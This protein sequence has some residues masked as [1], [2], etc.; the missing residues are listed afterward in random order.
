MLG[1]PSIVSES[2]PF[3]EIQQR[4]GGVFDDPQHP[5]AAVRFGDPR[6]EYRAARQEAALF[7][8]SGRVQ[9]EL[10]GRDRAKFLHNFCT[11][12]IKS[13]SAGQ[14]REAFVTNVQGKVLAH[15]FVYADRD[16]LW[17]DSGPETA[18][19]LLAHLS[20]Y[21][22]SEDV[23]FHDRTAEIGGLYV[24]GPAAA[25]RLA[26]LGLAESESSPGRHFH[27]SVSGMPVHVRRLDLLGTPGFLLVISQSQLPALWQ[28]LLDA[29]LPPAGT[30]AF[31]AL[32]IEAGTPAYGL[33]VTDANL[34]QEV[35][36]T[37][38]AISFTKGCYLGQEPIARIDALGHVNQQLRGVRF[39]P[40]PVPAPGAEISTIEPE[41]RIIGRI[42]SS[43][44]SL[45]DDCPVALAYLRR[46]SDA[47]GMHVQVRSSGTSLAGVV[48]WPNP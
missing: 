47:P 4:S 48:Y 46:N 31:E 16:S 20:K 15:I 32:R 27:S 3:R 29:G 33:D 24:A 17:L 18:E 22:I 26:R 41:P 13:L 14:G 38:Q 11:N 45:A 25:E 44:L 35:N 19:R 21:H 34:A 36:R 40:G 2:A 12:D 10:T 39:S 9:I 42:T 37:A 6:P 28:M 43:A 7:D 23:E 5:S 8:L 1:G 30:A